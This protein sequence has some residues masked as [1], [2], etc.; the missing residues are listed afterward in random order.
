MQV[1]AL[2]PLVVR[3]P[4]FSVSHLNPLV[5]EM[6][7]LVWPRLALG[8]RNIVNSLIRGIT[9]ANVSMSSIN[10][11]EHLLPAS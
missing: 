3:T 6:E 4:K 1:L 8:V 9:I 11:I 5:C 7:N 2:A 10:V